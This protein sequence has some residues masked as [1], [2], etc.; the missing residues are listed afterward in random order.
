MGLRDYQVADLSFYMRTPR[1]LNTSDPATGKTASVCVYLFFLWQSKQARS[2]WTMPKS[3]LDKNYDELM[4]WSEF[5]EGD[6]VIVDGPPAKRDE[7]MRS[8]ARVFLMGFDCFSSNWETL[9]KYH[10]DIDCHACDEIHMGYGGA[11]SKRTLNMFEAMKHIKYFVG[12]TGTIINGRYSSVYPCIEVIA[13]NLYG[14]EESEHGPSL[15]CARRSSNASNRGTGWRAK[16][17]T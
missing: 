10:P 6:V 7:Q 14:Q 9:L 2:V 13:P 15:H 12:M 11:N 8:D 5:V 3:L 1:C 16:I 17:S 4:A